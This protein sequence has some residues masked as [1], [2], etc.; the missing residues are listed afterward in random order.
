PSA[1]DEAKAARVLDVLARDVSRL[2]VLKDDG[3]PLPGVPAGRLARDRPDL[4]LKVVWHDALHGLEAFD[5][6]GPYVV[7]HGRKRPRILERRR[8]HLH[9]HYRPGQN[10][11][12]ASCRHDGVLDVLDDGGPQVEHR[13]ARAEIHA[14][15]DHGPDALDDG[16]QHPVALRHNSPHR[17]TPTFRAASTRSPASR[18]AAPPPY[19]PFSM[20]TANAMRGPSSTYG[21]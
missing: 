18:A 8:V 10:T 1:D 14:R 16:V 13:R 7:H 21:A 12:A 11:V 5:Q 3:E 6:H 19:P 15:V 9:D 17:I 4:H 20:T 2:R